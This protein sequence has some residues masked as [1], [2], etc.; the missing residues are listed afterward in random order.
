[1]AAQGV[2]DGVQAWLAALGIE[3]QDARNFVYIVTLSRALPD[4]VANSPGLRDASVLSRPQ[5]AEFV[6]ESLNNPIRMAGAQGRGRKVDGEVI[7][8]MVVFK[9]PYTDESNH[10]YVCVSG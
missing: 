4:T 10:F 7:D 9:E 2:V 8:T 5:A 1:M 3:M 6:R